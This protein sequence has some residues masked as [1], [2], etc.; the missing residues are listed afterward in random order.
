MMR[1]KIDPANLKPCWHMQT[2]VSAWMDGKLTGVTRW[3]TKTHVAHC[4]Q[5]DAS[6]PFLR[7]LRERVH[8]LS[9]KPEAT[10]EVDWGKVEAAWEQTDSGQA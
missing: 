9:N 1:H 10:P 5:C 7:G 4:P 3:Y 8:L 6:V 2:L